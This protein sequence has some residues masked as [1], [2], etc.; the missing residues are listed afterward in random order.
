[1]PLLTAA[2]IARQ[3]FGKRAQSTGAQGM[4]VVHPDDQRLAQPMRAIRRKTHMTQEEL[5][6]L[7]RVPV[8]D[9]ID[10]ELGRLG[11]VRVDRARQL[12]AGL[13]ARLRVTAWWGG[14]NADRILDEA[15][16]ALVEATAAVFRRRGWHCLPEFT[17]AEYGFGL[18]S[19][20]RRYRR[21]RLRSWHKS[22]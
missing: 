12:F 19:R 13:D 11:R 18:S 14:A 7:A 21:L 20:N 15:H 1:M 8:R 9:V 22:T 16:A 17:F 3:A 6:R 2:M 5:A 10:V 4:P